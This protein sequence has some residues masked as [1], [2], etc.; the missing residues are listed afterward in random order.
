MTVMNVLLID[1]DAICNLLSKK[2]LERMGMANE[3]HT[4]MNGTEAINLLNDYYQRSRSIPDIILLDLN[5]PIMDGFGF[6]EAFKRLPLAHKESVK[7]I[8]VSSSTNVRDVEKAKQMGADHYLT[9]PISQD[10]LMM[11]LA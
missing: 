3:I 10:K 9:K 1:D 2:T 7:I 11:A 6:L 4:A 8:I 5:M